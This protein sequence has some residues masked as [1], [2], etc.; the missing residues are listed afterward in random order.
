M[1]KLLVALGTVIAAPAF[2]QHDPNDPRAGH[3]FALLTCNDLRSPCIQGTF[4]SGAMATP[5]RNSN[6]TATGG[7]HSI[8]SARWHG[9]SSG[10]RPRRH[11]RAG[12]RWAAITA[13]MSNWRQ[14]RASISRGLTACS[15][16][17][18]L[19]VPFKLGP[20]VRLRPFFHIRAN[21]SA[22]LPA[23]HSPPPA[24]SG[25]RRVDSAAMARRL[26]APV[27]MYVGDGGSKIGQQMHQHAPSRSRGQLGEPW[28][29]VRARLPPSTLKCFAIT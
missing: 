13:R 8:E 17:P 28:R 23:F 22:T 27:A 7:K 20:R 16:C 29:S 25:L 3:R 15:V 18:P 11:S 6:W 9:L 5:A 10:N 1:R 14:H 2:A 4:T 24:G 21:N 12:T 19:G 26:R